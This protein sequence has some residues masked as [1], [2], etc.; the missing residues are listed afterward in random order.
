MTTMADARRWFN[1]A[2]AELR[3]QPEQGEEFV[4]QG[5]PC[6]P[7]QLPRTRYTSFSYLRRI[8]EDTSAI[9]S[10]I[11]KDRLAPA[12]ERQAGWL[13]LC[14][15]IENTFGDAA[16]SSALAESAPK[17]RKI[18]ETETDAA[19]AQDI[20]QSLDSLDTVSSVPILS[21]ADWDAAAEQ[22]QPI[23]FFGD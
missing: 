1:R 6:H 8:I 16:M 4:S 23:D 14:Q 20:L 7:G 19:A 5:G 22:H 9:E 12:A 18:G 11:P 13:S 3:P 2:K 15:Y 21:T 17:R 10:I